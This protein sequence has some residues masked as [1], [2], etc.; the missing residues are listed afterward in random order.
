MCR[1]R[2]CDLKNPVSQKKH[3][4][5]PYLQH[6]LY[7]AYQHSGRSIQLSLDCSVCHFLHQYILT[8]PTLTT[9]LFVMIH[10][11]MH[12]LLQEYRIFPCSP[13]FRISSAF[14][15][16]NYWGY[17]L[18]TAFVCPSCMEWS[19]AISI[20]FN[21]PAWTA[22]KKY[23]NLV[24]ITCPAWWNTIATPVYHI[25]KRRTVGSVNAARQIICLLPS[26]G[27]FHYST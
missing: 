18:I 8:K 1:N 4:H 2:C 25:L 12:K 13:L 5:V 15:T 17:I 10:V 23:A 21:S 14:Q 19:I 6:L 16:N 22:E 3:L 26:S 9:M 24:W 7:I 11:V 27:I 20:Q